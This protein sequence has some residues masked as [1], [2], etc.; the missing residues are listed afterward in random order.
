MNFIPLFF[1]SPIKRLTSG[2]T[3]PT[4]SNLEL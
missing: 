1:L 2:I 4:L 3:G